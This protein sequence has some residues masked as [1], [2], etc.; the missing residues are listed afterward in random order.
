MACIQAI[1][2]SYIIGGLHMVH[3]DVFYILALVEYSRR[4]TVRPRGIWFLI[5]AEKKTRASVE[6]ASVIHIDKNGDNKQ[7]LLLTS[8]YTVAWKYPIQNCQGPP[9]VVPTIPSEHYEQRWARD[10]E[11][12][13]LKNS[14]MMESPRVV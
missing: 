11:P 7:R 10:P 4:T 3:H 14:S 5:A 1:K 8:F 2:F 6:K 13:S 12:P 9:G